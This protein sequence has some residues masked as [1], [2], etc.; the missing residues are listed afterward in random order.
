MNMFRYSCC[1]SSAVV[2]VALCSTPVLAQ[3]APAAEPAASSDEAYGEIIVTANKREQNLS[4]VGLSIAALSGDALK[5]QRVQNV[6]DLAKVVPGLAYAPTPNATPVYTI[7]GV[8]FF[9]TTLS[10]YPDV[11]VYIDQVPLSLPVMTTLTAFDLERVEVLKGPQGTLFGNNATGGAINFIA[12]KPTRTL[13]GGVDL[14]Y[15]RFGT[16][17]Y[18]GYVSGPLSDTVRARVAFKGAQSGDWQYSYTRNDKIGAKDNLAARLLIDWDASETLKFSLNVNGWRNQDDPQ[19]PQYTIPTPQFP[20]GSAG[21]G[22]VVGNLPIYNYR[23]APNNARASDWNPNL[24]PYSDHHFFQ[25]ALRG[26]L[27]VADGITLTSLTG[28]EKMRFL[29]SINGSGTALYAQDLGRNEGHIES[30]TQELRVANAASNSVRWVLGGN[31]EH[32]TVDETGDVYIHDTSAS[33][34]N[35]FNGSQFGTFQTMD[36]YAAFGNVEFDVTDQLTLKGGIRRT[37]AKR[38][39]LLLGSYEIPGFFPNGAFGP[40]SL[41]AFFNIALPFLF[42]QAN[43]GTIAPGHS[44][45]IDTRTNPNGTPVDP[46]TYL[47]VGDLHSKMTERNT[48]WSLGAD[49]KPTENLLFYAN[50]AKGFKAGSYPTLAPAILGAFDP[51]VQEELMDYEAGFKAQLLDRKLSISGAAFYYDYKNKQTRAKFVDPIFGAL[52]KLLNVPKSRVKG[53]E[54]EFDA[55]PAKGLTLSGSVTYLD[56]KVTEFM[57]TVGSHLDANGLLVADLASAKGQPLP[58]APEWSYAIR[59]DY[60]FP[61]SQSL[62]GFVGA[63]AT[64]QTRTIGSIYILPAEKAAYNLPGYSLVNGNIGIES[65]DGAWRLTLWGKNIFNKLYVTNTIQAYDNIMRYTGRPVEYGV[66]LGIKFK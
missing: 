3:T 38:K 43:I 13:E 1:V 48:S 41:T 27:E 55:R 2:A 34:H 7:R 15:G 33:A 20:V 29:N 40:N 42:P 58:F 23:P 16:A 24:R 17:E 19:T 30:F 66:N 35:G 60:T 4:K 22:G 49:F 31:Y 51:V 64:G 52:D 39:G 61:L 28:Y 46:A 36:N 62:N 11:S 56:A 45:A 9:E 8:G 50:V 65:A 5:T 59:A 63:S 44:I 6:E 26:D 57:G 54:L 21:L 47:K 18:G 37:E 10:A 32:T 12:A 53:A 25:S 14:G